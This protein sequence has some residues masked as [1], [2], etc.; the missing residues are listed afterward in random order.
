MMTTQVSERTERIVAHVIF[1]FAIVGGSLANLFLE[2]LPTYR[3]AS[4]S[5]RRDLVMLVVVV[6]AVY[7]PTLYVFR[8]WIVERVVLPLMRLV[9]F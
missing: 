2:I 9:R 5:E 6:H 3:E 8:R 4:A 7:L 1:W